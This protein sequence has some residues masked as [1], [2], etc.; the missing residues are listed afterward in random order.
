M[1]LEYASDDEKPVA[2]SDTTTEKDTVHV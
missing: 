1:S 2:E